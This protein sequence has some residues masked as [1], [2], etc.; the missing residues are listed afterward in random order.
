MD[1]LTHL[2]GDSRSQLLDLVKRHGELTARQAAA[3]LDLAPTTVRQHFQR[4]EED[5]LVERTSRADGPGRPTVYFRLSSA[6]HNVY[7]CADTE[8]LTNLLDFL[9]LQGYHRTIDDFF[10]HFWRR[11]RDALA[12]RLDDAGAESLEARLEVL[13]DFLEQQGFMPEIELGDDGS[14]EIRECNCPLRGA[15]QATRLPCRL[16]SEF[17]QRIVGEELTRS[18]YIPDGHTACVYHFQR[19]DDES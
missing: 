17:L 5:E 6:G 18:H 13:Q 12:R 7:P 4:L 16:E 1:D 10:H 11:R 14:V 19:S 3:E 9:S 15:V 8:M 2:L